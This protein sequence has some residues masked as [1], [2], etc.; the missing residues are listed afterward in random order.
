MVLPPRIASAAASS[1]LSPPKIDPIA[2]PAAE[3]T[4]DTDFLLL[5][6]GKNH[7]TWRCILSLSSPVF[8]AMLCEL[9]SESM[10]ELPDK[11]T[12]DECD[13]FLWALRYPL[14]N[15]DEP[16]PFDRCPTTTLCALFGLAVKYDVKSL[17]S[18]L[19]QYLNDSPQ[20][21]LEATNRIASFC[22]QFD[23]LCQPAK[24]VAKFMATLSNLALTKFYR[25][26]SAV[27]ELHDRAMR[28]DTSADLPQA[29]L[30]HSPD[31]GMHFMGLF[32]VKQRKR[33]GSR[34][35]NL[36]LATGDALFDS[37]KRRMSLGCSA[38]HVPLTDPC[39]FCSVCCDVSEC[40]F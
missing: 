28:A 1:R 35:T 19:K 22:L 12:S 40:R 25:Y 4:C 13:W 23:T 34:P 11:I 26:P 18:R 38:C 24:F 15:P 29:I 14:T 17:H 7:Y 31:F 36:G 9:K 10:I 8:Q 6:D 32:M 2:V 27:I 37:K 20:L 5:V 30:A 33:I 16:F 3:Q 21:N 39:S